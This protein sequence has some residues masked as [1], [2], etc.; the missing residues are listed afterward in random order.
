MQSPPLDPKMDSIDD[1]PFSQ[2]IAGLQSETQSQ[3]QLQNPNTNGLI[4]EEGT[5]QA[6]PEEEGETPDLKKEEDGSDIETDGDEA[7]SVDDG[8]D[9]EDE[10]GE[11]EK[12]R[13]E[14]IRWVL[15][16]PSSSAPV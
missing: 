16:V 3:T 5:P 14:T 15:Y 4:V 12:Q 11:Y 1:D 8:E 13:Q 9:S 7:G 10:E 2:S 6:K